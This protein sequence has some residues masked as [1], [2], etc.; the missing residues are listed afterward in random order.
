MKTTF[1]S[2][3]VLTDTG[4]RIF[5]CLAAAMIVSAIVINLV[6]FK[7]QERRLEEHFTSHGRS[8]ARFFAHNVQLGVFAGSAEMLELPVESLLRHP[9]IIAVAV[10][11]MDG[12]PIIVRQAPAA[13]RTEGAIVAGEAAAGD[14]PAA[15]SPG[16]ALVF[17]EPVLTRVSTTP[18]EDLYFDSSGQATLRKIGRVE[19]GF[20]S[21][22][23]VEGRKEF[24]LQSI[25]VGVVFLI[26]TLPLTFFIVNVSTRPL[27]RLLIRINGRMGKTGRRSGDV[28]FLDRTYSSLLEELEQ[29]FETINSLRE[30]LE[31]KVDRRTAELRCSNSDLEKTLDELKQAQMQ[32]VHSEKMASLGLLATGLA[33]EINNALTLIRGSLFPLEKMVRQLVGGE[34]ATDEEREKAEK[35]LGEVIDHIN[36]GVQRISSLIRDLLTFARPGKGPR[37]LVDLNRELEMTLKLLNID[38]GDGRKITIRKIFSPLQP[39]CCHGSQIAQVFLNILLNAVQA[40]DEQGEIAIA[41]AMAGDIVCITIEDTGCGIAPEVL[42]KIFDPFFTTKEVGRG[43]GLGLGICHAIVHE[44]RGEIRVTSRPGQGTRFTITLPVVAAACD[45]RLPLTPTTGTESPIPFPPD[46]S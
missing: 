28:E 46:H 39:V 20:S 30:N 1:F 41:T 26:V 36:T 42:P 24:I 13:A 10:Y 34:P 37:H 4:L 38:A 8:L 32:L 33:H 7:L 9:D 2:K 19:I 35:L 44:H 12:K 21:R 17:Q 15:L 11:D 31:E 14:H 25:V 43:T 27:N 6:F 18:E 23:L 16:A 3:T 22:N 5:L 45:S 29:S 40:I